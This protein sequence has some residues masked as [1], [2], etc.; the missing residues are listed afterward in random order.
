MTVLREV[1]DM[2]A[3]S[4]HIKMPKE[5]STDVFVGTQT[6]ILGKCASLWLET[7]HNWYEIKETLVSCGEFASAE[8]AE[9]MEQYNFKG[10]LYQ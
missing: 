3:M 5:P 8:I 9:L 1:K 2:K 7:F 4:K 6:E 10:T